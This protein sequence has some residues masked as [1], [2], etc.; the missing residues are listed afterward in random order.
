MDRSSVSKF[1]ARRM[2]R[3]KHGGRTDRRIRARDSKRSLLELAVVT[4][5]RAAGMAWSRAW[6]TSV[7]NSSSPAP[8]APE[9][10]PKRESTAR[11]A[12][13][14]V[15]SRCSA[16]IRAEKLGRPRQTASPG[17]SGG[18]S[19]KSTRS[20]RLSMPNGQQQALGQ[21]AWTVCA[22]TV[23]CRARRAPVFEADRST[24][25][26][27]RYASR[28]RGMSDVRCCLSGPVTVPF[29]LVRRRASCGLSADG[30]PPVLTLWSVLAV[31]DGMGVLASWP[32]PVGGDQATPRTTRNADRSELMQYRRL[33]LP[34]SRSARSASGR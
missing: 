25:A 30:Q 20:T 18:R 9:R 32:R 22:V 2:A 5:H 1:G 31:P 33:G 7:S 6:S 13:T 10:S 15:S 26:T 21:S 14:R 16:S 12:L 11:P 24:A 28:N 8:S 23:P 34:A 3:R 19:T 27:R 29:R 17:M 4:R